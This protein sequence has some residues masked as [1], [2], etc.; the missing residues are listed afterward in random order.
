ME[1]NTPLIVTKWTVPELQVDERSDD[2]GGNSKH[3]AL[4]D[5]RG[6]V[7]LNRHGLGRIRATAQE[8]VLK[9][10]DG[11]RRGELTAGCSVRF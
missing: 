6:V 3:H 2:G 9:R 5:L 1:V 7:L 8:H 11:G 4:D 10:V